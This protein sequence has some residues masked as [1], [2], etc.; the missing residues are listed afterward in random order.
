MDFGL[1]IFPTD[2]TV[3]P[4]TL[5]GAAEDGGFDALFVTE[6]THIP[7]RRESPFPGGGE[8]PD[9]YRRTYDPFVAL[10]FAAAATERLEIGTGICLVTE[11]DPIVTAKA[12]ASLHR[13]SGG[14]FLFGVGAGWNTEEMRNHGTDPATRWTLMS[15]R[16]SAMRAIWMS[17]EAEFHGRYVDF[18]PIWSWPKPSSHVPVLVGGV[19]ERVLDRVVAF[20]DEWFPTNRGDDRAL[21]AQRIALLQ[22]KAAA[23]GRDPI[24]VTLY[25]ATA[26]PDA[27]A[28]YEQVGV[29]RAVFTLPSTDAE[30]VLGEVARLADV[31]AAYRG[32]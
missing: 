15:E 28:T 12:V 9:P 22:D 29:R 13:L 26:E 18:D 8:L 20:G 16:I 4:A 11:R 19:G 21:L 31:V 32:A 14:R 30:T 1:V 6:H 5:A 17:D 25:G 27:L 23:A 3:D 2:L 7:V 10:S 24:P